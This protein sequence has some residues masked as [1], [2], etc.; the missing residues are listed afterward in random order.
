MDAAQSWVLAL[1]PGPDLPTARIQQPSRGRAP[2]S[3][4][5]LPRTELGILYFFKGDT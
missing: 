2:E 3:S 5:D 1:A 4:M